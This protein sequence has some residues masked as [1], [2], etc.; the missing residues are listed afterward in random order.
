MVM[1]NPTP[2]AA[3]DMQG[4]IGIMSWRGHFVP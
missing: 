4:I 2:S 3:R 1:P